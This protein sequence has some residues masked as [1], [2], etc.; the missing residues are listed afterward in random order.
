LKEPLDKL[1]TERDFGIFGD[2]KCVRSELL[3]DGLINDIF[4]GSVTI[5]DDDEDLTK[6]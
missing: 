5:E 1:S 4:D 2:V 6:E 3:D